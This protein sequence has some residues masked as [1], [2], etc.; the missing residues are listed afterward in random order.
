MLEKQKTQGKGLD[1]SPG[2]TLGPKPSTLHTW[3]V[4]VQPASC[5]QS[6]PA[7]QHTISP[8]R[9]SQALTNAL[10]KVRFTYVSKQRVKKLYILKL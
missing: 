9:A 4:L 5:P 1:L 3:R 6:N 2:T 10:L 7:S 8:T